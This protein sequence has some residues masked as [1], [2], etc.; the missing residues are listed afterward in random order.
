VIGGR[1][2]TDSAD[3][4]AAL[5]FGDIAL[6]DKTNVYGS[7]GKSSV[8]LPRGLDLRTAYADV[9]VDHWFGPIGARAEIAYWGDNDFLDSIDGRGAL[10]WRGE[11][12]TLT[13]NL[14]YRDFEFDVFRS[15]FLSGRD[16]RFHSKGAGLRASFSLTDTV[17]VSASGIDYDYNVNLSRGA[18]RDIVDF[19]SVSRLSL[20]NSLISYRIGAGIGVDIGTR[21]LGF[22]HS[23]W[24]G[25]VDGS[26]TRSSTLSFLTPVS[27]RTD[28]QF[29]IG[30]DDSDDLDAITFFSIQLFVYGGN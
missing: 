6:S 18:N 11:R 29:G 7:Y 13:L 8:P 9:G 3:G 30:I 20:I 21:R 28:L 2:D 17:T 14:E 5:V 27:A 25:E 4:I 26:K 15:D 22:D 1:V 16:I 19:L 23:V 24:E 10:Y 12:A